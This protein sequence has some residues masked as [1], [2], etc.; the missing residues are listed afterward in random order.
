MGWCDDPNSKKYNKLVKLPCNY[1][2]EKLETRFIEYLEHI[3]GWVWDLEEKKFWDFISFLKARSREGYSGLDVMPPQ[4]HPVWGS[5]LSTIRTHYR[6]KT[7]EVEK[8]EA[9]ESVA[10]WSWEPIE[11]SWQESY[12]ELKILFADNLSFKIPNSCRELQR[13]ASRQRRLKSQNKLSME[14]I[15]LLDEIHFPW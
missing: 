6:S 7:L 8:I 15:N 10:G 1:K 12:N 2:A 11:A 9:L 13:F 14:R 4:S 5:Y 3:R